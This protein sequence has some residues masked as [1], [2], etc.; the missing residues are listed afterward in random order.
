MA[1]GISLFYMPPIWA[2][3]NKWAACASRQSLH[4]D[5]PLNYWLTAEP[6]PE[7]W[8][9]QALEIYFMVIFQHILDIMTSQ[10]LEVQ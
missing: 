10:C 1:A 6:A 9:S 4:S 2:L 7:K 8:F 5:S 3:R